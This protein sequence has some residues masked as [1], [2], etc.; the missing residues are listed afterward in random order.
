MVRPTV[1]PLGLPEENPSCQ[2]NPHPRFYKDVDK[3]QPVV[4]LRTH[5]EQATGSDCTTVDVLVAICS[6]APVTPGPRLL[7]ELACLPKDYDCV[8]GEMKLPRVSI[9]EHGLGL[10]P[11]LYPPTRLEEPTVEQ[12][13]YAAPPRPCGPALAWVTGVGP[14]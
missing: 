1:P 10:I 14:P 12:T 13:R 9:T 7:N 8:I 4:V 11:D 6:F 2:T 3:S 5:L